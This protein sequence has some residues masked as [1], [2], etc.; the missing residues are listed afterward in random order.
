M[1]R[2]ILIAITV[3]VNCGNYRAQLSK[4][5]LNNGNDFEYRIIDKE[6][7]LLEYK[8]ICTVHNRSRN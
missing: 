4:R 1:L 6:K 2:K 3:A 7:E 5:V 8:I